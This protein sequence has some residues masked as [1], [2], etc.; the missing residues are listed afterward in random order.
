MSKERKLKI[1]ERK[2]RK[3]NVRAD[4]CK[5]SLEKI[6]QNLAGKELKKVEKQKKTAENET[7]DREIAA[8]MPKNTFF[9]PHNRLS[10]PKVGKHTIPSFRFNT[11]Q[12]NAIFGN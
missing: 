2:T 12:I 6:F 3:K 11:A 4:S 1:K 10:Y 5:F 8:E 7:S 9:K